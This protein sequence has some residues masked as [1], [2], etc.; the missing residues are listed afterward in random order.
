MSRVCPLHPQRGATVIEYAMSVS[1]IAIFGVAAVGSEGSGLSSK[2]S[3]S[4]HKLEIAGSAGGTFRPAAFAGWV[5]GSNPNCEDC[6]DPN[7]VIGGIDNP[8]S[9][10]DPNNNIAY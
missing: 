6:S 8:A 3:D 7:G 1:L 9:N 4:A 10:G 2:F 5:G